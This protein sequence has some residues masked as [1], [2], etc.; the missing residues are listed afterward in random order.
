MTHAIKGFSKLSKEAKIEWLAQQHFE[1]SEA[2]IALLKTYWHADTKRQKLH[3]EFIENTLTNYYLP[4]GVAPNFKINGKV[5]TLPMAIEESSVVAAASKAASFWFDRGGFHTEVLSTRKIGHV[6]FI[7]EGDGDTLR[8]LITEQIERFFEDTEDI[9]ANMRARGGGILSIDLKDKT[10]DEPGYYQLEARFETCDSMGAN[11]INSCLEQFAR[12]LRKLLQNADDLA[13]AAR[14]VQIVM[15]ILSNYTPECVVRAEVRCPVNALNAD[16]G[17]QPEEFAS[18]F[19]RAVRIAEIEPYRATT[20][21]KGIFNGI[22]A[23][24]IATGN[25]FRA[26]EAAGHTYA[27]RTGRYSSL[28]HCQVEKGEFR[29]WIEI[30][31][32]L[33]TVGGLTAL[34]PMV[35]LAHEMLGHPNA[36][37]LMQI[38]AASGLAQN[39]AALRALVTTGIQKGHMKMHLFNI[40]NQLEATEEERQEIVRFFSDKVVAHNEV[41]RKFC[42]LRGIPYSTFATKKRS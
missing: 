41:V 2:A 34:H 17:I 27:S 13:P 15:C 36:E 11:F 33:G 7:Y 24:V 4:F 5:Y 28:T 29:F 12:T 14:E 35:K 22:D 37:E 19:H 1:D 42:E 18:K 10:L 20:H 23:V 38:V 32:A 3:D 26:V 21:N 30:P 25:D 39:F 6:H 16:A 9:T 31:L 8:A 40:L